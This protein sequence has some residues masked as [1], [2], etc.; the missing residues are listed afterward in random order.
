[1]SLCNKSMKM[2]Y[3]R[4]RDHMIGRCRSLDWAI[5][6][7]KAH[8]AAPATPLLAAAFWHNA[9]GRSDAAPPDSFCSGLT[10]AYRV[11]GLNVELLTYQPLRGLGEIPLTDAALVLPKVDFDKH[12]QAGVPIQ[13]LSD[14]IRAKF[15]LMREGG[16][17]I[18]GDSVWLRPPPAL[19]VADACLGHFFASMRANANTQGK[20]RAP[21]N[22]CRLRSLSTSPSL[23]PWWGEGDRLESAVV[24]QG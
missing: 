10:S 5:A 17:F 16:W 6:Q 9:G 8:G 12:L 7:C 20:T 1:M 14:Y 13:I 24:A 3:N 23:V 4:R 15:L 18:D 19:S 22:N 21:C 11:S 2:L